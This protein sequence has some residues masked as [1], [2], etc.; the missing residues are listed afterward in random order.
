[1]EIDAE[2]V[3]GLVRDAARREVLQH[4]RALAEADVREKGPGDLVTVADVACEQALGK[5]LL[6]A[7]PGSAVLGEEAAAADPA[8]M[9]R[10][11]AAA[12]LWV[13]DP[14]DGTINFAAGRPG[15]AVIVALVIA[16]RTE[17]GWIHDPLADETVAALSGGGAWRA[18]GRLAAARGT[19]LRRMLGSAYGPAPAGGAVAEALAASGGIG[20]LD[21]RLCGGVEYIEFASGRRHFMLSARSL[22]WDH[23]AGALI[24]AEAGGTARFLDGS[25]YDPRVMDG[26]LLVAPDEAA[27]R[28]L[29]ELIRTLPQQ[30]K[31]AGT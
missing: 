14:I 4:F 9:R 13:I 1:M 2:L 12:P 16:G 18:G 25:D 17:A 29:Q 24:A 21:N 23:A 20:R 31:R 30:K 27:W 5:A 7:Y 3:S 11:Y 26:R 10:L 8:L 19:P 6:D 28:Q 22:P 15:F